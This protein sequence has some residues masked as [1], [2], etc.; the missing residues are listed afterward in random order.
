MVFWNS[1]LPR[2]KCGRFTQMVETRAPAASV[3][4][5]EL[6]R[7]PV[8]AIRIPQLLLCL[9]PT[10]LEDGHRPHS[11]K[12]ASG[13]SSG[14]QPAGLSRPRHR[15]VFATPSFGSPRA[16]P[17]HRRA[18]VMIGLGIQ[19]DQAEGTDDSGEV[20]QLPVR[21]HKEKVIELLARVTTVP[22]DAQRV[23]EE[24]RKAPR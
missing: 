8:R 5:M 4:A 23:I 16:L 1:Y 17:R 11:S 6:R 10:I 22:M 15:I 13:F 12:M 18:A 2:R 14:N 19:G 21:D 3:L 9:Q 7:N 20:R 24:M